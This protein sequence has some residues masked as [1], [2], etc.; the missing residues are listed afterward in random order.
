MMNLPKTITILPLLAAKFG[1]CIYT[2][3]N[4]HDSSHDTPNPGSPY[5]KGPFGGLL[6]KRSPIGARQGVG[7]DYCLAPLL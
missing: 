5:Y 1:T 6:T 2:V 7:P 3:Y 4:I